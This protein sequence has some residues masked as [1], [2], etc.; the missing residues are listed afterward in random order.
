MTKLNDK[1]AIC[2]KGYAGSEGP[3]V[4]HKMSD[5][6]TRQQ[7][8]QMWEKSHIKKNL[9]VRDK[10]NE[11]HSLHKL[12]Q[13]SANTHTHTHAHSE[14]VKHAEACGEFISFN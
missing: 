12:T 2:L 7:N 13:T 3:G 11:N 14:H 10:S 6:R 4:G 8:R 9:H 5:Y 1:H